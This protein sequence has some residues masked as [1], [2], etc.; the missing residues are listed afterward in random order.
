MMI[1]DV[2]STHDD[3]ERHL[4]MEVVDPADRVLE[5]NDVAHLRFDRKEE[6]LHV[7]KQDLRLHGVDGW[8]TEMVDETLNL[9]VQ[10]LEDATKFIDAQVIRRMLRDQL[11]LISAISVRRHGSV[12]FVPKAYE[13]QVEALEEL[14]DH[15][16]PGS[17]FIAIPLTDGTKYR[18]M[19][20][21]AFEAEVHAEAT[22]AIAEL[23]TIVNQGT[24]ITA[25]AFEKWMGRLKALK[26]SSSDYST[27]VDVETFKA[28]QGMEA[29]L[30][31]VLK[32]GQIKESKGGEK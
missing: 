17:E 14:C 11:D 24:Q 20:T 30:T 22:Q 23:K 2:A 19:I 10:N 18:E 32:N 7:K 16:G 9:F 29:L 15:F 28:H 27:M 21:S 3:I 8:A 31:T 5:H 1:R 26:S 4:V 12:Y 6:V 13:D 25:R